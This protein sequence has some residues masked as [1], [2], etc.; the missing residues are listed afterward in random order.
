M[1]YAMVAIA[2]ILPMFMT[3]LTWDFEKGHSKTEKLALA[4]MFLYVVYATSAFAAMI[5]RNERAFMEL[6]KA[7]FPYVIKSV[8]SV[9]LSI[10]LVSDWL[11]EYYYIRKHVNLEE[12][13]GNGLKLLEAIHT[14][15]N[16]AMVFSTIEKWEDKSRIVTEGVFLRCEEAEMKKALKKF[17]HLKKTSGMNLELRIERMEGGEGYEC[18]VQSIEELPIL[19]HNKKLFLWMYGKKIEYQIREMERE[20]ADEEVIP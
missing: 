16:N 1:L 5:T 14:V 7:V 15:L 8:L 18:Y 13:S 10:Y 4:S 9:L 2:G 3:I 20:P 12:I 19:I 6:N 11:I 17:V